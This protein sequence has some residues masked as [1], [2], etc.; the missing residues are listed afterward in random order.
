MFLLKMFWN[1]KLF[2]IYKKET[3][4]LILVE[5]V[6][7]FFGSKIECVGLFQK[8][9]IGVEDILFWIPLEIFHFFTLGIPDKVKLHPWKFYKIVLDPLEIPSGIQGELFYYKCPRFHHL[10]WEGLQI[11]FYKFFWFT[12]RIFFDF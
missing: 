9:E 3:V 10:I 1:I 8:K 11:I 2:C 12:T 7:Q 5:D 4:I 6:I